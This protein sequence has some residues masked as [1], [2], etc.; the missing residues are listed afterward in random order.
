MG[1]YANTAVRFDGIN[2]SASA[3]VNLS[4]T[5]TITVEFWMKWNGFAN[6]D[7]L[8]MELTHNFNE[9][10]GGFLIDPTRRSSAAPSGSGSAT[11]PRATTSS[12]PGRAP[13]WHHYA[14]VIDTAAAAAQEIIP[15]VDGKAVAFTKPDSG[16]GAGN[17]ANSS[18]NFM[19]RAGGLFGGG[20][21]RGRDLRQR[22]D[23]ATIAAHYEGNGPEGGGQ[24]PPKEEKGETGNNGPATPKRSSARP[25]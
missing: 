21:R 5:H 7:H 25:A 19:S 12:S 23:A 11:A 2:D 4:A 15:Y 18:L 6:D 8:A 17:F 22:A 24:E 1:V 14:F 10:A 3:E 16:T 13:A 9:N 20:A